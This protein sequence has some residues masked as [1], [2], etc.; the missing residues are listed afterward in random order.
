VV[1]AVLE[2]AVEV[3]DAVTV[4]EPVLPQ[5]PTGQL[6]EL[7]RLGLPAHLLPADDGEDL[8]AALVSHLRK[9]PKVPKTVNRAGAV[10]AVV[11]PPS[12][13]LDVARQVAQEIGLPI[14]TAVFLASATRSS[15]SMAER[16]QVHDLATAGVRRAGWRRRRG[17]T[18]VAVDAD[19]TAAG[20]ARAR[21]FLTALEPT[22][23][24]GVVEATRK[25]Q[26]VGA[27][28]RALGG[29]HALALTGVEE[30]AD[31][32]AVLELGIPVSRLGGRAATP[33]VWAS[34]LT[35]RLAA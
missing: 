29:V 30:T 22:A 2:A 20:A 6:A 12:L 13:A 27:W 31:P 15:G 21:A 35:G 7:A 11:G 19:L 18:V 9:L 14:G 16:Q 5:A 34:L 3:V 17:L 8:Y 32:A 23:T 10:L 4:D 26:D 33:A 24:W 28:T 1:Q 25:A